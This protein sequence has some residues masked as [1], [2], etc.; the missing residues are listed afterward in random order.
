MFIKFSAWIPFSEAKNAAEFLPYLAWEVLTWDYV[1]WLL[2]SCNYYNWEMAALLRI[3]N[4]YIGTFMV[5]PLTA[6]LLFCSQ[7][8]LLVTDEDLDLASDEEEEELDLIF[9]SLSIRSW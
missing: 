7:A 9:Y 4:F 1:R 6:P 8:F 2:S 5:F 3:S